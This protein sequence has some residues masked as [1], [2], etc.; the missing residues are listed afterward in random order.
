[1]EVGTSVSVTGTSVLGGLL[2][3]KEIPTTSISS[4]EIWRRWY[5]VFG[6]LVSAAG[7]RELLAT[8]YG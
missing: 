5:T 3:R 1:M 8:R 6:S 4:E 2:H 7:T